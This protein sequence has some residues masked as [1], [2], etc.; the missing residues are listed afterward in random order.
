VPQL[1]VRL[2]PRQHP[3]FVLQPAPQDHRQIGDTRNFLGQIL[4]GVDLDRVDPDL[5]QVA[6]HLIIHGPVHCLV[7]PLVERGVFNIV[8]GLRW[9]G[10]LMDMECHVV[11]PV[12]PF[13][14]I[15][16]VIPD[17]GDDGAVKVA[18]LVDLVILILLETPHPS[19]TAADPAASS[20]A[21]VKLADARFH[22]LLFIIRKD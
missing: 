22:G 5:I 6:H 2:L 9:A 4:L 17:R 11:L 8:E 10:H 12:L 7:V 14:L 15:P 20:A 21:A 19:V 3:V 16:D 13:L 1:V 18:V